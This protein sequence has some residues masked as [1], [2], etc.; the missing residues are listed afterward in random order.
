MNKLEHISEAFTPVYL[1]KLF[2]DHGRLDQY[3]HMAPMVDPD[4]YWEAIME[5]LGAVADEMWGDYLENW[6]AEKYYLSTYDM[7]EYYRL[8][9]EYS[10]RHGIKLADNP[11]MKKAHEYVQNC[12][13]CYGYLDYTLLTKSNH[14]W[15]SGIVFVDQYSY[16]TPDHYL[17]LIEALMQVFDF[18]TR[19]LRVLKKELGMGENPTRE[20][21]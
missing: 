21:A 8:C 3:L 2:H 14:K 5:A 15:A 10:C 6:D 11:Y 1:C 18:Y 9:R 17:E 20:A 13:C 12:L 7:N 19:E 4:S 16:N